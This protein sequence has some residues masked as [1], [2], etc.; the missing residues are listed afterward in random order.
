MYIFLINI[1][2]DAEIYLLL[3]WGI[4]VTCILWIYNHFDTLFNL[5]LKVHDD[6]INKV[7]ILENKIMIIENVNEVETSD[8][9]EGQNTL[10]EYQD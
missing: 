9:E 1:M 8:L 4:F 5:Q 10:D 7:I 2:I 6:I 3:S